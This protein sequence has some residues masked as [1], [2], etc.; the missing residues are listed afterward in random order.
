MHENRNG[1]M[2]HQQN[3]VIKENYRIA[4]SLASIMKGDDYHSQY[5]SEQ[6]PRKNENNN[7]LINQS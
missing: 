1:N 5:R 3:S 2:L 4:H 7:Y 6:M